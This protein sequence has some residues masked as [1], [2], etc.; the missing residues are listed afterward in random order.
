MILDS[1]ATSTHGGNSLEQTETHRIGSLEHPSLADKDSDHHN[2]DD[3]Y[4]DEMD[5]EANKEQRPRQTSSDFY[6]CQQSKS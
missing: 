4:G 1:L 2:F 6:R 3:E 5:F